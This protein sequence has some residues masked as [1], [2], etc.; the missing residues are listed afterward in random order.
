M[1]IAHKNFIDAGADVIISNTYQ[2]NQPLL[3]SELQISREEAD[4]LLL[5]T[6]DLA[7]KAAG[8][9]TIVAG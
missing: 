3:M 4:N 8:S 6:V 2:S 7:R 1:K 9:E 5:K